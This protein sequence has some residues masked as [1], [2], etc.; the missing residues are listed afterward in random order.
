MIDGI[1]SFYGSVYMGEKSYI[2][3]LN[4]EGYNQLPT[5]LVVT[6]RNKI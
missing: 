6:F 4:W 2:L 5:A 3:R 1:N